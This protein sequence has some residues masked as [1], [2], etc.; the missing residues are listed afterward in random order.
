[1]E[2]SVQGVTAGSGEV[3]SAYS[4]LIIVSE[5]KRMVQ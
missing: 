5:E 1:M 4:Y 3:K 2:F